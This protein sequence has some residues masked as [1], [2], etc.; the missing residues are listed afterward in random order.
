MLADE[1][2]DIADVVKLL[3]PVAA[4]LPAD[5][6]ERRCERLLN[7]VFR[8]SLLLEL[9]PAT[10]PPAPPPPFCWESME[11]LSFWLEL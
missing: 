10:P 6:L 2:A 5:E 7:D 8:E 4:P 3:F 9:P 11:Q 1:P